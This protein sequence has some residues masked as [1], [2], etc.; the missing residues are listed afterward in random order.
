MTAHPRKQPGVVYYCAFGF[1]E[2]Q[3]LAHPQRDQGLADDVLHRLP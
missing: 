2:V 3:P 1:L